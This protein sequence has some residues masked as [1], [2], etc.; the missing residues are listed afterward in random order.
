MP[1]QQRI[2]SLRLDTNSDNNELE[3]HIMQGSIDTTLLV[4][5]SQDG[6]AIVPAQ[7]ADVTVYTIYKDAGGKQ[8]GSHIT[9]KGDADYAVTVD[10]ST[11]AV[12]IPLT[13]KMSM[14]AGV[15][16]MYIKIDEPS[17]VVRSYTYALNY[18][19][20]DNP[21]YEE[22]NLPDELPTFTK[23]QT[24][25]D[26]LKTGK[27]DKDLSNVSNQDFAAKARTAP[28]VMSW[29]GKT[30]DVTS[31]QIDTDTEALG[32][33][34]NIP[35]SN[36]ITQAI[37]AKELFFTGD[38][39]VKARGNGAE[40][41]FSDPSVD[42]TSITKDH[43]IKKTDSGN[44][45]ADTGI[46]ADEGTKAVTFPDLVDAKEFYFRQV[47]NSMRIR[48]DGTTG[49]M[50]FERLESGQWKEKFRISNSA[51]VDTMYLTEADAAPAVAPAALALFNAKIIDSEDGKEKLR[52]FFIN[53]DG[54][55]FPVEAARPD[56]TLRV[57]QNAQAVLADPQNVHAVYKSVHLKGNAAD[58]VSDINSGSTKI[59]ASK[60]KNLPASGLVVVDS[61]TSVNSLPNDQRAGIMFIERSTYNARIY[62]NTGSGYEAFKA[63]GT[64]GGAMTGAEIVAAIDNDPT[65]PKIDASHID[66]LPELTPEV[67]AVS[68]DTNISAL[69]YKQY[70]GKVLMLTS[71]NPSTQTINLAKIADIT[72]RFSVTVVNT[73]GGTNLANLVATSPDVIFEEQEYELRNHEAI[74][75][76]KPV[77]G[78]QW[79]V[80]S[81]NAR[82]ID[83]GNA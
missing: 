2:L 75:I 11:G 38:L 33:V 74:T 52:P 1:M 80:I 64:T 32:F 51:Q 41:E 10:G 78:T 45:F 13:E 19:V 21:V 4:A 43:I 46:V 30:G 9:K 24:E 82:T 8:V 56:G 44:G 31:G 22:G 65:D 3:Q 34:K 83:G 47:E 23:V 67:I 48:V 16:T 76:M 29:N 14:N 18:T 17:P 61:L 36:G 71:S 28:V 6:R 63:G 53:H 49:F 35:V 37:N 59:D 77:S 25:I 68:V 12:T 73:R 79:L 62:D 15:N 39:V 81:R 50:Y 5:L 72:D 26:A 40:I 20:D 54:E 27:A 58:L 7:A 42:L 55:V 60:I 69:N 57:M 66:N 70:D